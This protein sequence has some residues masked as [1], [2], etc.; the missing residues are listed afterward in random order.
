VSD[1]GEQ[2]SDPKSKGPGT[3][4]QGLS[5][6]KFLLGSAAT[7]MSVAAASTGLGLFALS[8]R[9]QA[10]FNMGAFLRKN[11]SVTNITVTYSS[12]D[13]TGHNVYNDAKNSTYASPVWSGSG[14]INLTIKV[15]SGVI[16]GSPN[17][18]SYALTVPNSFP[19]GSTITL[20]N[21]GYIVGAGGA[22]G[23]PDHWPSGSG[24]GGAGGAGGTAISIST[25]MTINNTN[26]YIF[27]GGGGG[28]GCGSIMYGD[29]DGAGGGQ[30]S[31]GGAGSGAT[32]TAGSFSGPGIM[33]SGFSE[34]VGGTWGNPGT[35]GYSD[36]TSGGPGGAA[37]NAIKLNGNTITWAGGNNSTRV[38][39]AVN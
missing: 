14:A 6:R 37:G 27:G 34:G 16:L 39:G 22:G 15:N 12:S 18:S 21:S 9:A 32:G 4:P 24:M 28:G 11:S 38:K 26:G 33:W 35:T 5:R 7:A 10:F 2:M 8:E 29:G 19:N 17:A 3:R 25:A 31:A 36:S 13:N 30:G 1:Y 20:V 23:A